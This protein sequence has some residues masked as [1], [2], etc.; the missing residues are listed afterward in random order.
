[1]L[2][3][4]QL[5]LTRDI[6]RDDSSYLIFLQVVSLACIESFRRIFLY[7]FFTIL[8]FL[9]DTRFSLRYSR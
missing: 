8:D 6:I 7:I 2:G 1:V 3:F 9:Y 4:K 5:D